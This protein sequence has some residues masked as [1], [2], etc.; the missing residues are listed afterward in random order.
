MSSSTRAGFLLLEDGTLFRGLRRDAEIERVAEVVFTTNMTGYQEVFTD[1]SYGD[2]I[3]VMTTPMIGNYGVN[4]EDPESGKPQVAG[5]VVRELTNHPSNWRASGD[6]RGWL[7][8]AQVPV[9]EEVDTRRLTRHLRSAGVMRGIIG[10]GETPSAVTRTA[11]EACPSMEG[12]DLASRASTRERY[13]WGDP[14]APSHIV[15]YDYG[16]KRN[17]LRLFAE[18]GC[19]VTVVPAGTAAEAVLE[20]APNGVF[21]ANG[22]GDPAAVEYAPGIIRA[23]AEKQVPILGI[24]LGHQLLGLTFGARTEKMPY[25]HRGGNHPVREVDT[26]RVL[27]TSQNHGFAVVGDEK[28]I[29]GAPALRVTHVNL[30]DGTVEGLM[31]RE[32]PVFAVQYH[33][34]AAPGPHDA[35]PLFGEFL[36]AVRASG[37]SNEPNA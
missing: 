6:L 8:D 23:L 13:S 24:C 31:H 35:R 10:N 26:D 25:G 28:G 5:V 2:Q 21:L 34:E 36:K 32:L 9:L 33:P 17:I 29:P 3:V 19:R 15:A 7:R 14:N 27:I 37:A 11:L 12:L 16:I 20:S 1:P 30:N 22:P 4:A 18:N